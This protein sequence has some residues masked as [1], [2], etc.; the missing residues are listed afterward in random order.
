VV[1]VVTRA[2]LPLVPSFLAESPEHPNSPTPHVR[3]E[4]A[5]LD[6][7]HGGHHTLRAWNDKSLG[8]FQ[9]NLARNGYFPVIR[10]VFPYRDL[11]GGARLLAVIAPTRPYRQKEID[12]IEEFLRA[13]GKAIVSVGFEELH[14]SREL[15]NRFGLDVVNIPLG[16]FQVEAAGDTLGVLFREAWPVWYD[17]TVPAEVV[18]SEWEYP[19]V[20]KRA[21]GKGEIVLIGDSYFFHDVNLETREQYFAGNIAFLRKLTAVGPIE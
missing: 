3:R 4:V 13:G 8:G 12:V 15:L 16:H 2:P 1:N 14:A 5:V 21:V 7:S 20:V 10:D 6:V 9:I 19:L 18:F 17:E 11:H